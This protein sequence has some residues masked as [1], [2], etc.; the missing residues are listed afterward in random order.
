MSS[1]GCSGGRASELE[2]GGGRTPDRREDAAG[3]DRGREGGGL[4]G[5]QANDGSVACVTSRV[6][7]FDAVFGV[8]MS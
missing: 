3:G 8:P 7:T 6:Q 2:P 5:L 1:R 4:A